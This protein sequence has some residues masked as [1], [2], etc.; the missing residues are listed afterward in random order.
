[1]QGAEKQGAPVLVGQLVC[2]PP[3]LKPHAHSRLPGVLDMTEPELDKNGKH[4]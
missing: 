1:M 2:N 3:A 4:G